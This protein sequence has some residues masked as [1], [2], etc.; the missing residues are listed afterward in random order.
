MPRGAPSAAD[1]SGPVAPG[2]LGAA[3]P[4]P[5]LAGPNNPTMMVAPP[6]SV[7]LGAPAPGQM[8]PPGPVGQHGQHGQQGQQGQQG[9]H[10]QQGPH[11]S[12]GNGPAMHPP[13]LPGVGP[14]NL[15]PGPSGASRSLPGMSP[16]PAPGHAHAG[17]GGPPPGSNLPPQAP[18]WQPQQATLLGV[19][20][21]SSANA[22]QPMNLHMMPPG[23]GG[24]GAMQNG[25]LSAGLGNPYGVSPYGYGAGAGNGPAAAVAVPAEGKRAHKKSS[26]IRDIAIGVSIAAVVLASFVVVKLTVLDSDEPSPV[27]TVRVNVHGPGGALSI[28]GKTIGPVATTLEIPETA[29]THRVKI[30]AN[31]GAVVCDQSIALVAGES[32][33]VECGSAAAVAPD[34]APAVGAAPPDAAAAAAATGPDAGPVMPPMGAND[35]KAPS[36]QPADPKADPGKDPKVDPPKS[37]PPKADPPKGD[38]PKA[39]PG[40]DPKGTP[41][42]DPPKADPLPPKGDPKAGTPKNDP[43]GT[44]SKRPV[45][46]PKPKE[47][48]PKDGL[49]LVEDFASPS[50]DGKG[51]L[52]IL[53]DPSGAQVFLDGVDTGKKTPVGNRQRLIAAAG[54]RKVTLVLGDASWNFIVDIEAGQTEA[55][56]ETL[57]I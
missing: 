53:S 2:N 36:G 57:R 45:H 18:G 38:P 19:P 8:G 32:K 52:V 3:P 49:P 20:A 4:H 44:G 27:A 46:P 48:P 10:G 29:G 11:G 13:G 30:V 39:D 31:D 56:S 6:T 40:K 23:S 55:L 17:F 42:G 22:S 14:A 7:P 9:Q 34:A 41:K 37:D 50:K 47:P 1:R 16:G 21:P 35:P 12:M 33:V 15:P 51:Y 43:K 26:V 24:P 25:P 5:P 28:D 54:K